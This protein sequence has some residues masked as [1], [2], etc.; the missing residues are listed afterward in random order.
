MADAT[1]AGVAEQ[2]PY[3]ARGVIVIHHQAAFRARIRGATDR[4]TPALGLEQGFVVSDTHAERV[5]EVSG[6]GTSLPDFGTEALAVGLAPG[7]DLLGIRQGTGPPSRLVLFV[8]CLRELLLAFG[9]FFPP[10]PGGLIRAVFVLVIPL[11]LS[12]PLR[13]EAGV[14]R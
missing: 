7:G 12:C 3:L 9:I 13:Q 4:A 5:F 8:L 14:H 6:A 1:V 11:E 10:L 2:L